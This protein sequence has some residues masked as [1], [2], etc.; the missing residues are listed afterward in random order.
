MPNPKAPR[1]SRTSSEALSPLDQFVVRLRAL[2]AGQDEIDAVVENWDRF[3]DGWTPELQAEMVATPD[4][5][6]AA[7]LVRVRTEYADQLRTEQEAADAAWLAE[8]E[9][10]RSEVQQVIGGNVQRVLDW[11]DGNPVRAQAA[12][13]LELQ[14]EQQ[15]KTV[16]EPLQ[17]LVAPGEPEPDATD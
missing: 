14:T 10:A 9:V 4:S 5:V 7:E 8:L 13:E 11:V 15:R 6:L 16:V 12:L 1:R 3:D 17:A 2:G